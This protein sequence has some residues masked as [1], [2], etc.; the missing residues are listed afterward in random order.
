[1]LIIARTLLLL[2]L[3]ERHLILRM[4]K[5]R[6]RLVTMKKLLVLTGKK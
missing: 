3:E 4:E 6:A 5:K 2:G 1:M